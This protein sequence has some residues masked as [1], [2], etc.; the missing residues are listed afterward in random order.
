MWAMDLHH[1]NGKFL[2]HPDYL[3]RLGADLHFCE[4][5]RL[6]LNKTVNLRQLYPPVSGRMMPQ[7]M[8]NYRAPRIKSAL[9]ADPAIGSL[10]AQISLGNSGGHELCLQVVPV[11]TGFLSQEEQQSMRYVPLH[12]HDVAVHAASLVAYSFAVYGFNT[13]HFISASARIPIQIAMAA[14]IRPCGR[15]MFKKHTDCPKNM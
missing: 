7:N 5:T 13:G 3:S 15:A 2:F 11:R 8:P 14:D 9:G 1:R 10:M 12:N 4:L 6:Y